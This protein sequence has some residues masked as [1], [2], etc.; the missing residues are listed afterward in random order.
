MAIST[1]KIFYGSCLCKILLSWACCLEGLGNTGNGE[2]DPT[3]M[4]HNGRRQEESRR[5][6]LN[7]RMSAGRLEIKFNKTRALRQGTP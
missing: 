1:E 4:K 7:S 3:Y 5:R 2:R 6:E